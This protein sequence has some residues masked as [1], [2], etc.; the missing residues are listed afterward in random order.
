M[1]LSGFFGLFYF[2]A[3]GLGATITVFNPK[4]IKE[5]IRV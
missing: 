2:G 1:N 5:K 3:M 4:I